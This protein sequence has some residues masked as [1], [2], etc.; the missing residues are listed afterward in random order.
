MAPITNIAE[1]TSESEEA[2]RGQSHA[3]LPPP[4]PQHNLQRNNGQAR[5]LQSAILA[6]LISLWFLAIIGWWWVIKFFF[7]KVGHQSL[8]FEWEILF[9]MTLVGSILNWQ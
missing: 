2:T 1:K 6:K 3:Q 8:A 7:G 4:T 9:V 5:A